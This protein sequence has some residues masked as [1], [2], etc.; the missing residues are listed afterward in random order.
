[1]KHGSDCVGTGQYRSR[2]DCRKKTAGFSSEAGPGKLQHI[3]WPYSPMCIGMSFPKQ[4]HQQTKFVKEKIH[5]TLSEQ[6]RKESCKSGGTPLTLQIKKLNLAGG[7][8]NCMKITNHQSEGCLHLN[9]KCF[10]L[11]L[12]SSVEDKSKINKR[13]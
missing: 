5:R 7:Y 3:T 1:M 4:T 12:V 2:R 9:P 13:N 8:L 6:C 10:S 11:Q